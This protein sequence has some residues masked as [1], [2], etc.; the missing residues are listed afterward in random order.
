MDPD[1]QQRILDVATERF[2]RF[3]YRK[4]SIDEIAAD[5][6]VGKGTVYL[7]SKNKQDLFYQCVHRELREWVAEVGRGIDPRVPADQL[8]VACT[9]A[10]RQYLDERPLVR[11]LLL[12]NHDEVMPMW[13][14]E[15]EGLRAMSRANT[16]EILHI[17]V[18]Q[19]LFRADLDV[20]AVARILQDMHAIG[21]LLAYRERQSLEEQARTAQVALDLL[22]NGLRTR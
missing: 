3:G 20:D 4:T 12:G 5:A 21:L 10:A 2:A 16:R 14:D 17:G 1:K 6:G 15:L 19:G 9:V 18:R 8:L 13:T 7:V 22:L 11:D